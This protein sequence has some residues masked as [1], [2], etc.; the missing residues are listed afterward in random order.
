[1]LQVAISAD[2]PHVLVWDILK[3]RLTS[4]ASL[5][6]MVTTARAMTKFAPSSGT[7]SKAFDYL[8]RSMSNP[9]K[10]A[11]ARVVLSSML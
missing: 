5:R 1:M 11:V 7:I 4:Q 2:M 6:L 3:R 9:G 10:R 8:H